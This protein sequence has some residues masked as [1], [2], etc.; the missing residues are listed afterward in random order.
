MHQSKYFQW[1]LGEHNILMIPDK[2]IQSWPC[3]CSESPPRTQ[4]KLWDNWRRA[5]WSLRSSTMGR[6]RKSLRRP[7]MMLGI[8]PVISKPPVQSILFK[9]FFSCPWDRAE[10]TILGWCSIVSTSSPYHPCSSVLTAI[11]S[12][13]SYLVSSELLILIDYKTPVHSIFWAAQ[14]SQEM[15]NSAV[16]SL[17]IKNLQNVEFEARKESV[18]IFSHV[19]RRQIGKN[20]PGTGLSC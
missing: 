5:C 3:L 4:A 2:P 1:M 8:V 12:R 9:Y 6:V 11:N 18:E 14:M 20:W 17:L 19:L 16:I 15:Y 10:R 7:T 13:T